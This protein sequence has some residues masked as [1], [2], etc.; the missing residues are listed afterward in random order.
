MLINIS[1]IKKGICFKMN[2]KYYKIIN[3]LHVKPGKG[4]AF[5]RTKIKNL[6]NGNIIINNFTSGNKIDKI[7]IISKHYIFIYKN[8]EKFYFINKNNYNQIFLSENFIGRKKKFLK[9]ND[10]VIINFLKKKNIPLSLKIKKYIYLKVKK[11]NIIK[12]NNINKKTFLEN[13]INIYT[14]S[15]IKEGDIIKINT[16]TEK[17]I[18]RLK[19]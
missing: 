11:T 13:G 14:P 15:F 1:K 3:F 17:Y 10:N 12:G 8:K 2:N 16:K 19:K 9:E 7:E 4:N 6:K 18:E 5:V